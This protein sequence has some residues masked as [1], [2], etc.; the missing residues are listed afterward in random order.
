MVPRMWTYEEI[1][2]LVD[3]V[4]NNWTTCNEM[5][6]IDCALERVLGPCYC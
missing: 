2:V 6:A 5:S 1:W 4:S 3:N